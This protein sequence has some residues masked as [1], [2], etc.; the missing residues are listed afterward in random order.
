MSDRPPKPKYPRLGATR[1][2]INAYH[3]AERT[4]LEWENKI[5]R[6]A[7]TRCAQLHDKGKPWSSYDVTVI[8]QGDDWD[9]ITVSR[10]CGDVIAIRQGNTEVFITMDAITAAVKAI[11]KA[12]NAEPQTL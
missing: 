4:R 2:E 1:D 7:L 3:R 5:M 10:F 8:Q 6:E 11:K 9:A 12:A